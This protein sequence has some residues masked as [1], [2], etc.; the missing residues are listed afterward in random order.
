MT[1]SYL[2]PDPLK[3]VSRW[4]RR[5]DR[6]TGSYEPEVIYEWHWPDGST[7]FGH[8]CP[9]E[10]FSHLIEAG[11]DLLN[12]SQALVSAAFARVAGECA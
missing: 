12:Q 1:N 11:P 2:E 9:R 8:S 10:E 6:F 5:W 3:I 7:S 4:T